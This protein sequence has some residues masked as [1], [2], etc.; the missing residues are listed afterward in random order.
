LEE[1]AMKKMAR[2]IA[3]PLAFICLLILPAQ[4]EA[5]QN[6]EGNWHLTWHDY[7]EKGQATQALVVI[8]RNR[9]QV[10]V[11]V[12]GGGC[13]YE[14]KLTD[15]AWRLLYSVDPFEHSGGGQ[16]AEDA[17]APNGRRSIQWGY[18][19]LGH[20]GG[21]SELQQTGLNEIRGQWSYGENGGSEIW[22]RAVPRV[23]RVVFKSKRESQTTPGGAP[24]QVQLDWWG[25]GEDRSVRAKFDLE[26]YGENLW[27]QHITGFIDFG[28]A[29]DMEF[30][31][32]F[33]YNI[34]KDGSAHREPSNGLRVAGIS[35]YAA[36]RQFATPGLKTL[37]V[38]GQAFP[39]ELVLDGYQKPEKRESNSASASGAAS[40]ALP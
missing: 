40:N 3:L 28:D 19:T 31:L 35:A 33:A 17:I 6:P 10:C 15:T 8:Y 13:R 2:R 30:N 1:K 39:F 5:Q 37:Y 18:G 29:V 22:R 26:I 36:I 9:E 32:T 24:A 14:N 25:V 11:E 21:K 4:A 38:N 23:Q 34:L 16:M 12:A 7:P 20:W 27:G